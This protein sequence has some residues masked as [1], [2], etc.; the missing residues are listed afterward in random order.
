[1]RPV[2]GF[3]L[4]E[5][6]ISLAVLSVSFGV[7]GLAVLQVSW[8]GSSTSLV[9]QTARAQRLALRTGEPVVLQL[10]G[11]QRLTLWPD[12]S[13][14]PTSVTYRGEKWLVNAWTGEVSRA[15]R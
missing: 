14:T 11:S 4:V 9:E 2:R 7:V 5:L 6:M 13:A 1:V 15:A 3:T 12:G 8:Q 10:D